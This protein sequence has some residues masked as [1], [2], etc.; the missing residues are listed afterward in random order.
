MLWEVLCGYS[1]CPRRCCG[2]RRTGGRAPRKHTLSSLPWSRCCER[3]C[4]SIHIPSGP[5]HSPHLR[6]H[7]HP[8]L[9]GG[10]PRAEVQEREGQRREGLR[11]R[12]C[13]MTDCA[14]SVSCR[15]QAHTVLP[16]PFHGHAPTN[17]WE[18]EQLFSWAKVP[19]KTRPPSDLK[20]TAWPAAS[21]GRWMKMTE[22][23]F[24]WMETHF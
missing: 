13:L 23:L 17:V 14:T 11:L 9:R 4:T 21:W 15:L 8:V 22:G 3:H 20:V 6:T 7:L 24:T 2:A 5:L 18:R 19:Q 12:G 1:G 16:E 10:A